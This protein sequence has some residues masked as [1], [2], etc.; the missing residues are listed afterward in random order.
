MKVTALIPDDIVLEVKLHAGGSS[1]TESLI[2]ALS[3]WLSLKKIKALN[4]EVKAEPL[5]F[6]DNFSAKGVRD[7][8]RKT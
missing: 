6:K 3:E 7:L 5:E 2:L 8:N 4:E 1:L